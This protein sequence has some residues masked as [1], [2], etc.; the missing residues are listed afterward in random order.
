MKLRRMK[1]RHTKNVPVFLS[2]PVYFIANAYN[3]L[4]IVC[5]TREK[6]AY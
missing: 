4:Y 6:A 5:F 1:L 2:H 3:K